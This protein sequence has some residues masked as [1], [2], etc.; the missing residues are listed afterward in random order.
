MKRFLLVSVLLV[1]GSSLFAS[2]TGRVFVDKNNNGIWEKGEKT[3]KG[4]KV[5][6]GLHVVET[7][8]D[9][10]YT[11]PGHGR[12]K[13]IFITTPSGYK[14]MNRHSHKIETKEK[15]YDFGLIPYN[16]GIRKDGSH[17]FI[18]ISDTEIFN[19]THHEDWVNNVRDYAANEQAAFIIHTGDI[20]Y[21]KG[22]KAHIRLMNTENMDCP[23][24]Y[25][26][27]NHDLE[28][29]KYGEEIFESVYGPVYYSFEVAGVHYIVTPMPWGDAHPGYTTED[30]C[31]W[32]KNDL[33]HIRPGT[34]Y[35]IQP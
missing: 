2:Y 32:L 25:C 22:L 16:P 30:V 6:D 27:G 21:E 3:L 19:T 29:G 17:R 35:D 33:A 20:C 12:E 7:G 23:V 14:T 10:T 11:L 4:V 8:T 31:N 28:R 26:I 34:H 24:F 1:T 9:G 5:S 15:G 18:H 13:F